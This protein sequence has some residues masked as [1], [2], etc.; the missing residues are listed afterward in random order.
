M[1]APRGN[2]N[3]VTHGKSGW[4]SIGRLPPHCGYIKRLAGYFHRAC[5]AAVVA[6]KGELSVYDARLCLSLG[7]LYGLEKLALRDLRLHSAELTVMERAAI[8][9]E[10]RET[11]E[12]ISKH[13]DKLGIGGHG[14]GGLPDP[15]RALYEAPGEAEGVEGSEGVEGG[16]RAAGASTEDDGGQ[17]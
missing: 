10:L 13:L 14:K 17:S 2:Q 4:T 8:R 7:K 5:E 1:G 12:L 3:A 11:A 16:Q 6:K 9:R 15:F